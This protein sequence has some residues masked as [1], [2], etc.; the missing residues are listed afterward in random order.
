[1]N[2]IIE[3]IEI[4]FLSCE[5]INHFSQLLHRMIFV[6]MTSKKL[7]FISRVLLFNMIIIHECHEL[8]AKLSIIMT[9]ESTT[10]VPHM[11]IIK[12]IFYYVHECS[13]RLKISRSGQIKLYSRHYIPSHFQRSRSGRQFLMIYSH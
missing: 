3:L 4:Y 10:C 13:G 12:T 8:F 6:P 2:Y 11:T 9:Q 7:K 1:M 5:L